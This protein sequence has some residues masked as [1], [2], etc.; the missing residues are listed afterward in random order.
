MAANSEE[1]QGGRD[2]DSHAEVRLPL[3]LRR[4]RLLPAVCGSHCCA[5]LYI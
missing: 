4:L 3:L 2:V 1:R 5:A